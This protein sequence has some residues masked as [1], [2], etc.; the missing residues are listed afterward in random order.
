MCRLPRKQHR[1][2]DGEDTHFADTKQASPYPGHARRSAAYNVEPT[3]Y[4]SLPAQTRP[5]RR[6]LNHQA[7]RHSLLSQ[8]P[9][10]LYDLPRQAAHLRRPD[11]VPVAGVAPP[12][13]RL[14]RVKASH[15]PTLPAA[16]PPDLRGRHDRLQVA[17]CRVRRR[18]RDVGHRMSGVGRRTSDVQ[19]EVGGCRGDL[20]RWRCVVVNNHAFVGSRCACVCVFQ[21]RRER[22]RLRSGKRIA[23]NGGGAE[24]RPS[25]S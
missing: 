1:K 8:H 16:T 10:L 6:S 9:R 2:P 22:T 18:T 7:R 3:P 14:V 19:C 13:H 12:F 25:V 21:S 5:H 23:E 24:R 17:S 4:L 15:R 11:A 20:C